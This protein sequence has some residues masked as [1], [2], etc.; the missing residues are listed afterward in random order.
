MNRDGRLTQQKLSKVK[1]ADRLRIKI[2]ESASNDD[3]IGIAKE[4][5]KSKS[6]ANRMQRK[7]SSKFFNRQAETKASKAESSSSR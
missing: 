4:L 7:E 6:L 3:L 2:K 1:Q 5:S